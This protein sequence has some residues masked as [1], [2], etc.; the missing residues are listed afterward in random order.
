L[1]AFGDAR[2]ASVSPNKGDGQVDWVLA[3]NTSYNNAEGALVWTTDDSALLG[4]SDGTPTSLISPIYGS[5]RTARTGM[6]T[7]WTTAEDDCNGWTLRNNTGS[8][9]YGRSD[10]SSDASFLKYT[11]GCCGCAGHRFICVE[12]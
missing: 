5:F 1:F 12:Q 10:G 9:P 7:D 3:P 2:V 6:E 11:T 8:E 4:V